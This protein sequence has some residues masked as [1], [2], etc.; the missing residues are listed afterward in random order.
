MKLRLR[1]TEAQEEKVTQEIESW[2]DD[3]YISVSRLSPCR[4]HWSANHSEIL[5]KEDDLVLVNSAGNQVGVRSGELIF[6]GTRHS[7]WNAPTMLGVFEAAGLIIRIDL[8]DGGYKNVVSADGRNAEVL[9]YF[10]LRTDRPWWAVGLRHP[11]AK[12]AAET[13][14]KLSLSESEICPFNGAKIDFIEGQLVW[15]DPEDWD[16][17]EKFSWSV[18]AFRRASA[19][20]IT[21]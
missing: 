11:E 4:E 10:S 19:L 21:L 13:L 12:R 18:I 9:E 8:P 17:R 14:D 7:I 1:L 20:G 6:S 2:A 16:H 5:W 3:S 15:A